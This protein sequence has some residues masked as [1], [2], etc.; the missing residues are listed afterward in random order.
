MTT[1]RIGL[2]AAGGDFPL[3][4]AEAAA[5][6]GG[7][8]VVCLKGFCDPARYRH[9]P[10]MIERPGA[11]GAIL[12]RLRAEGVRRVAMA[13]QAKRPS[14]LGLWPDAW[15]RQA[16]VTLGPALLKGDDAFLRGIV[17]LLEGEGFEVVSPQSLLEDPMAGAG[18]LAGPPPDEA[19][20]ADMARGAAVL[21]ALAAQDIGQAV[22]VQQGLVLGVEAIEGTDALLARAAALRREGPGGVL[23]KLPKQGQ[24]MRVDAPAIG[25]RTVQGAVAAGLRGIAIGAGGTILADGPQALRDAAAAGIFVFG[26]E[27]PPR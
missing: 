27:E 2:L 19:A 8:F 15:A 11:A 22:V 17:A 12:D 5:R 24:E 4:V 14:M 18:L 25:P 26:M 10:H 3:R 6:R 9:L 21:R 16:L 7:V 23:V 1:G 13:G 20:L